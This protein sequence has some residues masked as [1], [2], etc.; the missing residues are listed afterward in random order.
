MVESS[1]DEKHQQSM[2]ML[3]DNRKRTVR[4]Q[5]NELAYTT[6]SAEQQIV[7]TRQEGTLADNKMERERSFARRSKHTLTL[8]F[9][10]HGSLVL[11]VEAILQATRRNKT[12]ARQRSISL[13]S[14]R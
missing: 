6:E 8:I 12:K 9:K 2:R 10:L 1:V 11:G 7:C 4:A 3:Y 5:L 14:H 13:Q